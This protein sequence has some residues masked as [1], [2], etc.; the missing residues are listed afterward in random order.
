MAEYLFI[1]HVYSKLQ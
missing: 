1:K